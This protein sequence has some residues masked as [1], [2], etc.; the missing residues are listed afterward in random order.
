MERPVEAARGAVEPARRGVLP[1]VDLAQGAALV[2]RRTAGRDGEQFHVQEGWMAKG[3]TLYT[4]GAP[5]RY[6]GS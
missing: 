6:R 5:V 1:Q 3:G 2:G 4:D